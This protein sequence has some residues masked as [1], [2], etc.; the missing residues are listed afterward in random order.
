[1]ACSSFYCIYNTTTTEPTK[2]N[3]AAK[4]KHKLLVMREGM[5]H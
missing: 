2:L 4:E 1:M 5:D 3:K